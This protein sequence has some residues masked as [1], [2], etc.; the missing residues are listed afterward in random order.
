L[1]MITAKDLSTELEWFEQ[2]GG[3][4]MSRTVGVIKTIPDGKEIGIDKGKMEAFTKHMFKIGDD[5]YISRGFS[6]STL[7]YLAT[8]ASSP[9]PSE[10]VS[11]EELGRYKDFLENN[12]L[13]ATED[14]L[15]ADR[16]VGTDNAIVVHNTTITPENDFIEVFSYIITLPITENDNRESRT[17]RMLT[18]V[19]NQ[20]EFNTFLRWAREDHT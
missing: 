5:L 12:I 9:C 6:M 13:A 10:I 1:A 18:I 3:I 17:D 4:A 15:S 20:E 14:F 16:K 8:S 7:E 2:K 19:F 11:D